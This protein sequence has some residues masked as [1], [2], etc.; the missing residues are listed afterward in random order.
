MTAMGCYLLGKH[1]G[2][3]RASGPARI[4]GI[5]S[6]PNLRDRGRRMVKV[7]HIH[8]MNLAV[9]DMDNAK[10]FYGRALG[11]QQ[12]KRPDIGSPGVWFGCCGT[13]R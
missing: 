9:I 5:L 7:K 12:I 10:D 3:F 4:G 13:S 8:H 2:Q 6:E 1:T 11:L